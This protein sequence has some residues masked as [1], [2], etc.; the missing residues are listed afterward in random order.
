MQQ[1][2]V[3]LLK[4]LS[5]NPMKRSFYVFILSMIVVAFAAQPLL[6]QDLAKTFDVRTGGKLKLDLETGGEIVIKGWSRNQVEVK[7]DYEGGNAEEVSVDFDQKGNTIEITSEYVRDRR[8]NQA[9]VNLE[10]YIPNTFDLDVSTMGGNVKVSDVKG[11]LEGTSMGGEIELDKL[12]GS[13]NFTTMGGDISLT[14]SKV[15]GTLHTMGGDVDIKD[16]VGNVK[17]TTM[18]GDVTYNNVSNGIGNAAT[19]VVVSTMG[20]DVV[21]DEA[22]N[23]AD[24]HT[25]GGDISVNRAAKHVKATTMGGEITIKAIDGWVEANTMGGDMEIHMVG[26]RDGD[27]HVD[28]ESMGGTIEITVPKGLSIDFDI[29][30][31][32]TRDVKDKDY[33]IQS[34]F[35]VQVKD[36]RDTNSR[37]R[38]ST[39]RGTGKVNGGKN[40]MKI[41]TTNGNVII[42]ESGT[43]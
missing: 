5:A 26:G 43:N 38:H 1:H 34:D 8:R 16:V 24:L 39:I 11:T 36:D 31:R 19:E 42:K 33:A 18:G 2:T 17:G 21:V 14:A 41:R 23:G 22:M 4:T 12:E 7:V 28:L 40:K 30:I 20:G 35:D 27:R 29:E 13:V 25:M 3:L 6:A 37:N 10:I 32:V 15:D 9:D